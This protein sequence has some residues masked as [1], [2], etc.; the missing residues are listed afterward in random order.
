L[1]RHSTFGLNIVQ[2]IG[3]VKANCIR[4]ARGR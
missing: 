3:R 1:L 2:V 4:T